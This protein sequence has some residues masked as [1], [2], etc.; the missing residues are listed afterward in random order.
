MAPGAAF[1][2][3][4]HWT[5]GLLNEVG[6]SISEVY[7]PCEVIT[8]RVVIFEKLVGN[9]GNDKEEEEE[10]VHFRGG[11]RGRGVVEQHGGG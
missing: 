8:L 5:A 6:N 4:T 11:G 10:R 3:P 1:H 2:D 9:D 7:N